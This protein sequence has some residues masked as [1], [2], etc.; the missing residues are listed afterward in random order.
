MKRARWKLALALL[1]TVVWAAG[2]LTMEEDGLELD[3]QSWN[4]T[5]CPKLSIAAISASSNDGNVP[6]NVLDN[7]LATRWSAQGIGAFIVADLGTQK[8][9]CGVSIAWHRGDV[10]SSSFV[11]SVSSDGSNYTTAVT[12]QS[13][14]TTLEPESYT[15]G[16]VVVGRFVRV[17]VNGNTE[18]TWASI[19]ELAVFGTAA[20]APTG[21]DLPAPLRS[22]T[23][24]SIADLQ[25]R[26]NSAIPGDQIVLANGTYTTTAPISV[27][28][29]GTAANPIVIT[30]QSIGGAVVQGSAGFRLS[31]ASHVVIRGFKLT[32]RNA[33]SGLDLDSCQYV[34]VTRNDFRLDD[35]GVKSYWVYV[36]GSGTSGHNRIDHNTF[37]DKPTE[38]PF[39]VVYGPSGQMS[40]YD[41]IDHN[42]FA[43]HTYTGANG[44]EGLRLGVSEKQLLSAYMTVELNLFEHCDGDPEVISNKSSDNVI[45][46]NTFR[47][48]NGSIVMRHG[49]R[50]TVDGNFI[51]GGASGIRVHG[52][53]HRVINN[54]IAGTTGSASRAPIIVRSGDVMDVGVN[55]V[56]S[57]YAGYD[58]P[59]RVVVAFNTLV[60][61]A[62]G[63]V[64]GS[65]GSYAPKSC[66]V[67]NNVIQSNA[68][69]LLSLVAAE[70]LTAQGTIV[71]GSGSVAGFSTS[72]Y[73]RA[74]PLF[75]LA[76]DGLYRVG[77]T[78][79]VVNA[80]VNSA[81][82]PFASADMDGQTRSG[83]FDVG[84]DEVSTQPKLRRPLGL[85]DVG[86][87]AP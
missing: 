57:G 82:F 22:F 37:H 20:P 34:R 40:Q 49:N 42:Y 79:P 55:G 21:D 75:A 16:A 43:R 50:A 19:T 33:G 29:D 12:G 61:N 7:N 46:W 76:S 58:R 18:N 70:S 74:D 53:D 4:A 66:T 9:I 51:L 25:N 83:V 27:T 78:S 86:P 48:N 23:V 85:T 13:S 87:I 2:C 1:S 67:S 41:R 8:S 73:R 10:R 65:S 45:R 59:D 11:V 60:N 63:I 84:A 31:G 38:G 35:G 28:K 77:T 15:F 54:Y 64:I 24:S 68:G 36:H 69:T 6:Q 14:G 71:W 72:A 32:H 52:N 39:I 80:G 47:N 30:A 62:S 56:S 3:D 44:G 5:S 26:I 81:A 17:T